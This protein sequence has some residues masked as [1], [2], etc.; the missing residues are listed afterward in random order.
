MRES[1]AKVKLPSVSIN[2]YL[3]PTN[4][5]GNRAFSPQYE[6]RIIQGVGHWPIL[7]APQRFDPMLVKVVADITVGLPGAEGR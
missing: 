4:L 1:F 5:A 3:L 7:E 2:A 6:A